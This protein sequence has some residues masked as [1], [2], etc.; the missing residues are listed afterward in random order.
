MRFVTISQWI[1]LSLLEKRVLCLNTTT[2]LRPDEEE[3]TPRLEKRSYTVDPRTNLQIIQPNGQLKVKFPSP[4]D[5]GIIHYMDECTKLNSQGKG[6]SRVIIISNNVLYLC[7]P[8]N[9]SVRRCIPLNAISHIHKHEE[10]EQIALIVPVEYDLLL[11]VKHLNKVAE[12]LSATTRF[13]CGQPVETSSGPIDRQSLALEGG[14][15][16]EQIRIQPLSVMD[17]IADWERTEGR[18]GD[19]KQRIGDLEAA[20]QAAREE[21]ENLNTAKDQIERELAACKEAADAARH[22]ADAATAEIQQLTATAAEREAA[23]AALMDRV[24]QLEADLAEMHLAAAT[25]AD[26]RD[27]IERLERERKTLAT[28]HDATVADLTAAQGEIETLARK[29]EA[30]AAGL[31]EAQLALEQ[32]T[33]EHADCEQS[34]KSEETRLSEQL[35][36]LQAAADSWQELNAGLLTA[37]CGMAEHISRDTHELQELRNT[38]KQIP[39]LQKELDSLREAN[40]VITELNQAHT[41]L[42]GEIANLHEEI[43]GHEEKADAARN[44]IDE[45]ELEVRELRTELLNQ[46]CAVCKQQ[47]VVT[48]VGGGFL[49]F[50]EFI[51]KFGVEEAA[52]LQ[53][54]VWQERLRQLREWQQNASAS[55][56]SFAPSPQREPLSPAL[57][58]SPGGSQ[59]TLFRQAGN[60]LAVKLTPRGK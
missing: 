31:H 37:N 3:N 10:T 1:M 30:A 53:E 9:G 51:S 26:A 5:G 60:R 49:R 28:L 11:R 2:T 43:Q 32:R 48:H 19:R 35:Q 41:E 46:V 36:L 27:E 57:P 56:A 34:W 47:K 18:L 20:L 21:I 25:A 23:V 52:R 24:A 16:K 8:D 4:L 13:L 12:I 44:R 29:S 45:L 40:A 14:K 50:G 39:E 58:G 55:A 33:R 22:R 15:K 17:E 54:A 38:A 59:P 42:M 7:M 6:Q